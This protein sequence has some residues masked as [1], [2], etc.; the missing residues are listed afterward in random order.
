M[1]TL[2]ITEFQAIGYAGMPPLAAGTNGPT[3]AAQQ[4]QVAKQTVAISGTAAQS[5]PFNAA[6]TLIRIHTDSI[7]SFVV[8]AA[9][10]ATTSDARMVAGQT[11]YFGVP[12]GGALALSVIT[13]T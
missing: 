5:N 6:T 4:P 13:N 12:Q 10:S 8:G 3:Q 7:C 9:P 2:Y 1:A 11:E